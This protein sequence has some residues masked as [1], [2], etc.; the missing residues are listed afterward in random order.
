[1]TGKKALIT[2]G[3][4]G[5]GRSCALALAEE[6]V[7]VAIL[8]RNADVAGRVAG[9]VRELGVESLA[10][11]V[12]VSRYEE[13][14][15]V[16]SEILE[17]W[18]KIDILIN[19]AGITRDKLLLQ[20]KPEDWKAVIDINLTGAFNL[21]KLLS[22]Q[23]NRLGWGRI[24]NISS[25]VGFSGNPG[26]ANYTAAKAGMIGMTKTVAREMVSRGVTVNAVA[27]GMIDTD[28]T[29]GLSEKI[30]RKIMD[31]IP[32]RRF[33]TA[34]EVASAVRFLVSEEAGYITGQVIHVN[35]G[36]YM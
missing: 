14:E 8:A 27:P 31:Q 25:V 1:M 33:G 6:G 3:S 29:K 16:V 18:E 24:I 9:E 23:M 5:I 7:D 11:S 35:G 13:V 10:K 21:T 32:M 22:R 20:M 12:D 15:A 30:K 19:N 2:G 36:M 34:Q 28:M 17:K 4:R 26:Q